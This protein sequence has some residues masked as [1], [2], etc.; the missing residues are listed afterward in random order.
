MADAR[1][2]KGE[3]IRYGWETVK[4]N[5]WFFIGL[6]L[7]AILV[8]LVPSELANLTRTS[9]PALS[10]IFNIFYYVL[11]GF[12]F[13]GMT[14][15]A[16]EF[17]DNRQ[18]RI[19]DLFSCLPQLL[20]YIGAAI[21]YSLITLAGIILL[22]VPGII[23]GLMFMFYTFFIIDKN[24]GPI[25][26][27]KQSAAITKGAKWDLFFL[28]LLLLGINILG[29]IVFIVGLLVTI[30]LSVLAMTHVYRKLLGEAATEDTSGPELPKVVS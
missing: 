8:I 22:I 1:F 24:S 2:S 21:I 23:W 3:A 5:L 9:A 10:V 17:V 7:L 27:L 14:K 13:M 11:N 6:A 29:A 28:L 18:A 16:L 4:G 12:I 15:V 30:P 20:P 25:E 26:A 19:A